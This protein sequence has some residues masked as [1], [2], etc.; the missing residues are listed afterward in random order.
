MFAYCNNNPVMLVDLD[1]MC[2]YNGTA[3][4]FHRSEHGLPPMDCNCESKELAEKTIMT[5]DSTTNN[6]HINIDISENTALSNM[7]LYDL[8]RYVDNI[9][10]EIYRRYGVNISSE[11]CDDYMA[12]LYLHIFGWN[13]PFDHPFKDNCQNIEIDIID[14]TVK[15]PRWLIDGLSKCAFGGMYVPY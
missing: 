1:G 10:R 12:E 6:F 8:S 15:D 11:I 13:M 4:D 5:Y 9:R 7:S 2:P 14:G 3:A